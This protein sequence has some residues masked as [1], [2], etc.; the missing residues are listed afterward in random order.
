MTTFERELSK[1]S[2][3]QLVREE[4]LDIWLCNYYK[5]LPTDERFKRMHEE[6]KYLLFV[7]FL[8]QSLPEHVHMNYWN[9]KTAMLTEEDTTNLEKRGYNVEDLNWFKEQLKKAGLK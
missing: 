6:Q 3:P 9:S 5:V 1:A 2:F 8:E 4:T 7:G